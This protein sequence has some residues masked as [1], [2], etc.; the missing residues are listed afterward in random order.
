MG[1]YTKSYISRGEWWVMLNSTMNQAPKNQE[2]GIDLN[3]AFIDVE[4]SRAMVAGEGRMG[5]PRCPNTVS[6]RTMGQT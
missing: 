1:L 4:Q 5:D 6:R 3:P 2:W